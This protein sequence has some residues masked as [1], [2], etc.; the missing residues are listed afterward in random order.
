M[1][2]I[3]DLKSSRG[4]EVLGNG[5][6]DEVHQKNGRRLAIHTSTKRKKEK[7]EAYLKHEKKKKGLS[8]RMQAQRT[9]H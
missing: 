9:R 2:M 8:A 1:T 4:E 3:A 5:A 7:K 6:A